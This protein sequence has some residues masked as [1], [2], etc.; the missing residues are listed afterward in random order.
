MT[1]ISESQLSKQ[2]IKYCLIGGFIT[3]GGLIASFILIWLDIS[4]YVANFSV[5]FV[6]C[7]VSYFLNSKFTFIQQYSK[8]R[9]I[10]FFVGIAIAY[11]VNVLAIYLVLLY[12]PNA[13]YLAQ[14]IGNIFYTALGFSINKFW[15]MK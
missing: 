10:K 12:D 11:L 4:I 8:S 2:F 1:Y 7:C 3:L 14:F 13:K 9:I 6:G 5:Y 15:V